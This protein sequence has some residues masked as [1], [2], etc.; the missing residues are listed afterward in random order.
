L[1]AS[2]VLDLRLAHPARPDD[3][4]TVSAGVAQ[5]DPSH[6]ELDAVLANADEALYQA[7][8]AGRNQTCRYEDNDER[9]RTTAPAD[10]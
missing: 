1:D 3:V 2:H 5:H 7:K 4:V 8:Q 6:P 10:R 9:A